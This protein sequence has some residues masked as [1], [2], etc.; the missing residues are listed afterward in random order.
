MPKGRCLCKLWTLKDYDMSNYNEEDILYEQYSYFPAYSSCSKNLTP[1]CYGEGYENCVCEDL[2]KLSCDCDDIYNVCPNGYECEFG[3]KE[4]DLNENNCGQK[5]DK[6]CPGTCRKKLNSQ[7]KP[8]NGRNRTTR[9]GFQDKIKPIYQISCP[10]FCGEA[11]QIDPIGEVTT[12]GDSCYTYPDCIGNHCNDCPEITYPDWYAGGY[13]WNAVP[14]Q[15]VDGCCLVWTDMWN[16]FLGA[17]TMWC[18]GNTYGPDRTARV[19]ERK[20]EKKKKIK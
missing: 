19:W 10:H 8:D 3:C 4:P 13:G 5:S 12:T 7:I 11:Y 18:N 17:L 16:D 20:Y 6:P 15:C 14:L 9:S 2:D 1:V